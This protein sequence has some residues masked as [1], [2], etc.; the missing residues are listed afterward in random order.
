MRSER[1]PSGA[2]PTLTV[3][4]ELGDWR[5]TTTD[6]VVTPGAWTPDGRLRLTWTETSPVAPAME[7]ALVAAT[8]CNRAKASACPRTPTTAGVTLI[9]EM[10]YPAAGAPVMTG[11]TGT[12]WVR[13]WLPI[14][15]WTWTVRGFSWRLPVTSA[16]VTSTATRSTLSVKSRPEASIRT[17]AW[18]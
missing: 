8:P 17:S 18:A 5:W 12:V 10:L 3:R 1:A 6:T 13:S 4:D 9:A 14:W 7:I 16:P 2:T 11:L 15:I